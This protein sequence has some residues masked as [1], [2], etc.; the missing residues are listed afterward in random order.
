MGRFLGPM[1][2]WFCLVK[3]GARQ[4]NLCLGWRHPELRGGMGPYW[5]AG[6]VPCIGAKGGSRALVVLH[7]GCQT[8]G[9][10][11]V[12]VVGPDKVG[13][14]DQMPP[15]SDDVGTYHA[16][17]GCTASGPSAVVETAVV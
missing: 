10:D 15:D 1:L 5:H 12:Q 13:G 7:T 3:R 14:A 16:W 6:T 8:L 9:G 17:D 11:D 2:C 4:C